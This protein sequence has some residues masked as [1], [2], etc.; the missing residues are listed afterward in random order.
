MLKMIMHSTPNGTHETWR[1][2]EMHNGFWPLMGCVCIRIP[3]VPLNII[4]RI[5]F[6]YLLSNAY[7]ASKQRKYFQFGISADCLDV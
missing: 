3:V 5:F 2:G 6:R 1:R 4:R 7:L